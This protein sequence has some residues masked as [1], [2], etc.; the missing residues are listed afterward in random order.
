MSAEEVQAADARVLHHHVA[1]V[2]AI[3][4]RFTACVRSR[5]GFA[6]GNED[7]PGNSPTA[8]FGRQTGG[9]SPFQVLRKVGGHAVSLDVVRG[10]HPPPAFGRTGNALGVRAY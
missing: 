8:R 10:D 2:V 5:G 3:R 9:R 4:S 7:A 6:V 1:E